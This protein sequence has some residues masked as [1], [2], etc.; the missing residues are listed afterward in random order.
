MKL[1]AVEL[2]RTELPLVRPFRTSL[3]TET[4]REALLVRVEGPGLE[5]WGECVA[6]SEPLYSSEY[7]D[8][9]WMTLKR[10]IVPRLFSPPETDCRQRAGAHGRPEG[11][12]HG[13]SGVEMAILDA[14]LRAEGTSFRSYFGGSPGSDRRRAC[15][16]ASPGRSTSCS[17]SSAGHVAEGYQRVKLKIEPGWDLEPVRAVRD[18]LGPGFM[19]QVDANTA[20]GREDAEHLRRLDEFGLLLI[21]Q[22]L[23][24]EDILGH[25]ELAEAARRRRSASTSRSSR[26]ARPSTPIELGACSIVN[27]KAGRVGGYLEARQIHDACRERGVP[28]WC[29]GML[30]TGLGRAANLGFG[31]DAGFLAAGGHLGDGPVLPRGHHATVRPERRPDQ[32]S[33]KVLASAWRSTGRRSTASRPNGRPSLAGAL[34]QT[35]PAQLTRSLRTDRGSAPCPR[36]PRWSRR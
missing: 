5:G 30:E 35:Q 13:E 2:L 20:Y 25:V 34:T 17:T 28:V 8:A 1:T 21:E 32:R 23:D 31:D 29:G 3:G 6:G 27:I 22:P 24:E 4:V 14:E 18:L 15:P 33:L 10:F 7:L 26:R 16:S 19:L 9:A 12:P 11:S 36:P